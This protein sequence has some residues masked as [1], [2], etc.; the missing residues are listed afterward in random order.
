MTNVVVFIWLK[1][2]IVQEGGV[3]KMTPDC[4]EWYLSISLH[5]V[6]SGSELVGIISGPE[7]KI[8]NCQKNFVN[9]SFGLST[10]VTYK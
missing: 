3:K 7:I 1:L 10:L 6:Q 9:K 8:H 5:S 2:Q 4:I